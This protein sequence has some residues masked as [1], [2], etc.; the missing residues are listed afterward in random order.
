MDSKEEQQNAERKAQIRM[1]EAKD[2]WKPIRKNP[3]YNYA[4]GG[5]IH[6]HSMHAYIHTCMHTD[7]HTC[8]YIII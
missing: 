5:Q 6:T 1:S 4:A 2:E 3:R 7:I 8:L